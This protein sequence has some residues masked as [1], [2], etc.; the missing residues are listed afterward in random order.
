MKLMHFKD[1]W[2]QK[3]NLIFA[4]SREMPPGVSEFA[5]QNVQKQ[6]LPHGIIIEIISTSV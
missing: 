3:K 5:Y 1:H 2:I 6:E 4:T